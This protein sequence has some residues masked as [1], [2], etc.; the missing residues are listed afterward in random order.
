MLTEDIRKFGSPPEEKEDRA[1]NGK[2]YS[3]NMKKQRNLN[4]QKKN[5]EQNIL[6]IETGNGDWDQLVILVVI[7]FVVMNVL[8]V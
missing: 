6:K 1:Y 5:M 2:S 8:L 3:R 4:G 7:E